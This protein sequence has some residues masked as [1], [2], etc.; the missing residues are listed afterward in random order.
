MIS[1]FPISIP[2]NY[3]SHPPSSY[4]YEGVPPNTHSLPPPRSLI[5]NTG[6]LSLQVAK[7]LF[8]P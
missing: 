4:F 7:G 3:L 6:A 1:S 2:R 5:P 8:F